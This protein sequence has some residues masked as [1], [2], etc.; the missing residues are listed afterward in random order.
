MAATCRWEVRQM[1]C[2]EVDRVS[3]LLVQWREAPGESLLCSVQCDNPRLRDLDNWQCSGSCWEQIAA[4]GE[5]RLLD[6]R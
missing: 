5:R 2:P 6:R 4:K 1:P 3:S